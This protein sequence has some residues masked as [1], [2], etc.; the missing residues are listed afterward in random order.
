MTVC[1]VKKYVDAARAVGIEL[2]EA[3]SQKNWSFD[4]CGSMQIGF[5]HIPKD[6]SA[7]HSECNFTAVFSDNQDFRFAGRMA[8]GTVFK[9]R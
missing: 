5:S 4:S 7:S 2:R 6:W 9:M 8:A 1:D 3:V